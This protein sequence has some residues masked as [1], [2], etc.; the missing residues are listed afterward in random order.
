MDDE[1]LRFLQ[2]YFA[3]VQ[4][5]DA[6]V[7]DL[8]VTMVHPATNA[9]AFRPHYDLTLSDHIKHRASIGG[10]TVRATLCWGVYDITLSDHQ[11]PASVGGLTARATLCLG[12][13]FF[14]LGGIDDAGGC[15]NR[16]SHDLH[17][18]LR[19]HW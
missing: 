17:P 15:G 11:A 13:P 3:K 12:V 14:T 6:N 1:D 18:P 8:S 16:R 4:A 7:F 9:E 10:L 19:R 2:P 5:V